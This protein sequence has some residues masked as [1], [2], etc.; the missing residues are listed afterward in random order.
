MKEAA[1]ALYLR[2]STE[3]QDIEG[4]RRDLEAYTAARGWRVVSVYS[5]KVS[6]SGRIARDAFDRLREDARDVAGRPFGRVLVW[7]LD[8]WSREDSFV[9]AIGSLE[10][11]E[12]LGIRWHSLKEPQLDSGEDGSPNAGRDI[13]RGILATIAKFERRR[14]SDQ[15]RVAMREIMEG[16]RPTRSGR[17]P[18][19]PRKVRP[20]HETQI[21]ELR[22]T[23][24]PDGTV[25]TWAEVA[26]SVHLPATTCRKVYSALRS[27]TPRVVKGPGEFGAVGDG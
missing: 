19:R 8:R 24:K 6:G 25:R 21:R 9:Q 11:L 2:V 12:Q 27:K 22:E 23:R 10:E 3:D 13:L 1:V 18:G 5:E 17:P 16:R 7:A 14:R 15:T 20:E 4:Q 26:R